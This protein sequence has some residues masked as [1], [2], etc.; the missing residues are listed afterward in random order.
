LKIK[1][2]IGYVPYGLCIAKDDNVINVSTIFPPLDFA[3]IKEA[4]SRLYWYAPEGYKPVLRPL[5]DL[6]RTITHNGKEII[7]IVKFSHNILGDKIKDFKQ[8][9]VLEW[10]DFESPDRLEKWEI[11]TRIAAWESRWIVVCK[12]KRSNKYAHWGYSGEK[13]YEVEFF[14]FLNEIK[15]DYRGL[16]D[17]GLAIDAKTLENNP[18]K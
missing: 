7:P 3:Y 18:Y 2:V 15:I 17:A 6:Y 8:G 13:K 9:R 12:Y 14:D 5:S 11:S 1:D 16:I 10:L 4:S